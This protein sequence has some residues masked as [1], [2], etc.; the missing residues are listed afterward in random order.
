ML[1][2]LSILCSCSAINRIINADSGSSSV[3]EDNDNRKDDETEEE[4]DKTHGGNKPGHGSG[5]KE[6]PNRDFTDAEK[7]LF[8]EIAGAV[9]PFLITDEYH[10]EEFYDES[11]GES[12]VS[13][14]TVGNTQ[15]EFNEYLE[16]LSSYDCVDSYEDAY[17][18]IWYCYNG[19][20]YV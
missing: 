20:C 15:G 5:E 9:V 6:E 19:A 11:Y 3:E 4:D 1:L 10:V 17:G 7:A 13:Y 16:K 2:S 14:Y 12:C 8:I 18:D